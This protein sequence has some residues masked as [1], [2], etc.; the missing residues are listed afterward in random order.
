MCH[1]DLSY[2]VCSERF[3]DVEISLHSDGHHAV[4]TAC[5]GDLSDGEDDGSEDRVQ[6]PQVPGPQTTEVG[7]T[8]EQQ[9]SCLRTKHHVSNLQTNFRGRFIK[10]SGLP[11]TE[12]K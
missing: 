4:D 6:D 3:T 11:W 9:D 10:K 5:H 12:W 2:P 1:N 8:V 7:N